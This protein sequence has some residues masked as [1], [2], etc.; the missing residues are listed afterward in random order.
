[1][2]DTDGLT[3]LEILACTL[4]GEAESMGEQGMT[5]VACVVLNRVREHWFAKGI[6]DACLRPR[7]FSCWNSGDNADRS[8]ILEIAQNNPLYV[9]YVNAMRIAGDA[10]A[11]RITDCVNGAVSYFNHLKANPDWALEKTPCYVN[12]PVWYFNLD[13]VR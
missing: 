2:S 6:R 11:G 4:I 10:I 7:Q 1:M 12:E 5:E 3:N 8:R 9:P 13:A